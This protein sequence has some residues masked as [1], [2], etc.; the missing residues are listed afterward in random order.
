MKKQNNNYIFIDSQN[1]YLSI[2]MEW[3]KLDY[4]KFFIYLRDKF[5]AQKIFMCIGYLPGNEL[6][7]TQLQEIWYLLIFK[8]IL[9]MKDGK[10]KWNVDTELVLHS[11]I[12]YKNFDKAVIISGDGDFHCLIEHFL[13]HDKLER[14]IIPN[15]QKFSALLR[16]FSHKL[17]YLNHPDLIKKLAK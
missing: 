12:Q 7:Y 11:M 10:I 17:F 1:L 14:V 3:W 6:L 16:R 13:E 9:Q 2:K 8:P 4:N 15:R 5:H